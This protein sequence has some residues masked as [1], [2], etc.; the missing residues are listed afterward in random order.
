M[1]KLQLS[2]KARAL[3]YLSMREHSRLE[4]ARKLS[5]YAKE[6]EDI[7]ALL[8]SLEAAKLLSE[9][10]FSE[11]LVHRYARRF[12]NHRILSELLSHGVAE[13]ALVD[14]KADLNESEIARAYAVWQKKYKQVPVTVAERAKQAR[15]LLQRGF[16]QQA[17]HAVLKQRV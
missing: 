9:T 17:I 3:R 16:S 2:L 15:F 14:I 12:G 13:Q 7:D 1:V 5:R 10:R 11:S 8:D 6:D 4:L